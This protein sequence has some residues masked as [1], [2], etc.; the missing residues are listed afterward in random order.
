LGR[1]AEDPAFVVFLLTVV[2]SMFPARD[3]P[4][5]DLGVAGTDVAVTFADVLLAVT[6]LLALVRLHTRGR[7]PSPTLFATTVVF[8]ALVLVSALT[9]GADAVVSAGKLVELGALML[10]AAAFLVSAGRLRALLA[11][12]VGFAVV[13]VGWGLVGFLTS[14]RGRQA[15]FIGEHDL[16]ALATLAVAVGLVRVHT[17]RG[18]PGALG[19]VGLVTGIVGTVLGASLASLIGVYL[20]SIAVT[21]VAARRRDLRPLAAIV[22]V[23]VA[24]VAT[25]GTLALRQGELGFLQ[26]WFGPPP[27]RPGEYA[28]S[29]SQRLIYTYVGGRVFLDQPLLGT[30]WHG[31]LPPDEFARYVPDARERFP[32]QPPH[33]FPP[34]DRGFIPQQTY[35][36]VLFEL[37]LVGA[38]VFLVLAGLAGWRAAVASRRGDDDAAYVP[39]AWLGAMGGALAGAALFGGS[40]LTA[41]FWLTL[42]VV[43]A[44]PT[45]T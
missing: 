24:A 15:S 13:A 19:L 9:N 41:I 38:A 44:E 18:S 17:R 27:E 36:Q 31:L 25:G 12:L 21:A 14:D 11:V 40:P 5:L 30:G 4:A 7:I 2:M 34:T 3:L 39:A 42:G 32:D 6:G 10:G 26:A 28:S 37:G 1:W 22:T 33:Y 45:E 29:W 23:A 35:D 8:A 20:A 16:A 43:A